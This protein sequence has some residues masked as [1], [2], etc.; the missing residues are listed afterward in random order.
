MICEK[1][2][3]IVDNAR[4]CVIIIA[5]SICKYCKADLPYKE[6]FKHKWD[7]HPAESRA[8]SLRNLDQRKMTKEGRVRSL[9]NTDGNGHKPEDEAVPAQ[10]DEVKTGKQAPEKARPPASGSTRVATNLAEAV[11]I[12]II[13]KTITINSMLF[14]Q[15]KRVT[16]IE[17]GWPGYEPGDWLD[18]LLFVTFAQRGIILGAYQVLKKGGDNGSQERI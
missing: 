16:E 5:M 13:P 7:A 2:E 15:A 9:S 4:Y 17:W 12:T 18:T 14:H 1:C 10:S 6:L 3:R 8:D 11:S